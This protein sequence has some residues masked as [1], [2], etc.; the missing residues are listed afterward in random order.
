MPDTDTIRDDER[1]IQVEDSL[2][3]NRIRRPQAVSSGG[4]RV[5]SLERALSR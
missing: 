3:N 5:Q 1:G 4:P 2:E